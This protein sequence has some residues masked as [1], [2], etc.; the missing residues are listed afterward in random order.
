MLMVTMSVFAA[1]EPVVR[2][3]S[4]DFTFVPGSAK[5]AGMG[6]SGSA[7]PGRIDSFF[8]NPAALAKRGFAL[9]IPSVSMT[10][11]NV[12][13]TLND[14]NIM[15]DI[16]EIKNQEADS[17]IYADIL[18]RYVRNLG[19]DHNIITQIDAGLG[20]KFWQI[21]FG[22][23]FQMKMHSLSNGAASLTN[24]TIIP[25]VNVAETVGLGFHLSDMKDM[26]LRLGASAHFILKQY[27]K[28]IAANRISALILDEDTDIEKF[29][30]WE[31]PL[32][33]G[34][35]MTFDIGTSFTFK[36]TFTVSA[37]A[38]N[39]NGL[40]HMKS[41]SSEGDYLVENAKI[42]MEKP[43][44]HITND[45]V[46]F[47]IETPWNLNVGL[48]VAPDWT[49]F[50]PV[51]S[52]DLVDVLGLVN[53][54]KEGE[55]NSKSLLAHMNAGVEIS[56]IDVIRLRGGINRGYLSVGAGFNIFIFQVDA[57][58]SW[59]EMGRHLGDKPVDALTIRFNLGYDR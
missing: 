35:A 29:T 17:A 39:L 36:E 22:T 11:F 27:Y 50:R 37:S 12:S 43:E 42:K 31:T 13:S 14:E 16:E 49:G 15:A 5:Y 45:S 54:V 33:A 4:I 51:L 32:M 34:Y 53:E 19:T 24:I 26:R 18:Q 23:N 30:L 28:G 46:E 48:A 59:M 6:G 3:N 44:G 9:S 58:Y 52:V 55:F 47:E 56:L 20:I 7:Y 40:Y 2:Y 41:Y 57:S 38:T 1:S 21:G 10:I 8:L 25:E